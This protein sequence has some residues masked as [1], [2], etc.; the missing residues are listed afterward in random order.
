MIDNIVRDCV[1]F[2]LL[3]FVVLF[4]FAL[5]LHVL[6]RGL[7]GDDAENQSQGSDGN[8]D[9]A[10]A[11]DAFGSFQS[12]L[13]TMFYALLGQIEPEVKNLHICMNW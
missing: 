12:S 8:D 6:L 1:A 3:A 10:A 7:S 5:A 11:L 13:A 9:L 4:G 2:L